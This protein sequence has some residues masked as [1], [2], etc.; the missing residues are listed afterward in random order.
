MN[1]TEKKDA[2]FGLGKLLGA[3]GGSWKIAAVIALGLLLI[4]FSSFGGHKSTEVA[5]DEVE[6]KIEE[7]CRSLVGVGECR[8]MVTYSSEGTRY[9][10]SSVRSVESV[11]IVC[12]GADR[13]AVRSE[14]VSMISALYGI[15]SNRI[16]ISRMK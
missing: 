4:V 8:V 9:G 14:L 13:A 2:G 5:D 12:K 1:K 10:S 15:G 3:P 7:M 16:F 6:A 11:A